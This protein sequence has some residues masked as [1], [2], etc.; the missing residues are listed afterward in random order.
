MARAV[1]NALHK[2]PD[3]DNIPCFRVVNAKGDILLSDYAAKF[4][5]HKYEDFSIA[6]EGVVLYTNYQEF[7]RPENEDF[8]D[9]YHIMDQYGNEWEGL[10][11]TTDNDAIHKYMGTAYKSDYE[12]LVPGDYTT[13]LVIDGKIMLESDEYDDFKIRED[14][15]TGEVTEIIGI[16]KTGKE[17]NLSLDIIK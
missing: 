4:H 8:I 12:L 15:H 2:N 1:G 17:E 10:Y 9:L 14:E 16:T 11:A 7:I 3:P 5:N 13:L 6:Q